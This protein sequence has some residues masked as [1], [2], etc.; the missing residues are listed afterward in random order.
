MNLDLIVIVALCIAA[1]RGYQKGL[2]MALLSVVGTVLGVLVAFKFTT[3]VITQPFMEPYRDTPWLSVMVF[4]LLVS[5]TVLV[6]N[7]IGRLLEK[8]LQIAMLGWV[9]RL[10]GILLYLMLYLFVISCFITLSGRISANWK[11]SMEQTASYSWIA[12]VAPAV[13]TLAGKV[14]PW[15][16]SALNDL[17]QYFDELPIVPVQESA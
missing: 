9:N 2:L 8:S 4:A 10:G 7:I 14:S 1:F 6:V 16:K 13:I 3:I 11:K 5:L 12:P 15:I 17:D